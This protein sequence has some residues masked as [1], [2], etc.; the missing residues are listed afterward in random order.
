MHVEQILNDPFLNKGTG[1]TQQERDELGLNGLIPPVVRTI[2][3]QA[4]E[5]YEQF[6]KKST[7]LEK[8]F[9][10]MEIFNNNRILFFY[11]FSRH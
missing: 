2:D 9:F 10:L 7:D 6:A 5:V 3:E 4:T 11:L 1:F 8:R